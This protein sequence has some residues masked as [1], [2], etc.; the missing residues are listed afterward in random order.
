[1]DNQDALL[2]AVC[3]A[4]DLLSEST[5]P[6]EQNI[7]QVLRRLG[8]AAQAGRVSLFENHPASGGELVMSLRFE[9]TAPGVKPQID[10]LGSQ[11]V[12]YAAA[13]LIRWPDELSQGHPLSGV[14]RAFPEGE[15]DW[16]AA[17]GILSFA[18]VPVFARGAWWGWVGAADCA[19]ERIWTGAQIQALSAVART[20]G[21]ALSRE[22]LEKA[23][24]E[25]EAQ[26]LSIFEATRDGLVIHALDGR[27]VEVNPSFCRMHGLTRDEAIGQYPS[28]YVHP[29]SL[30]LFDLFVQSAVAGRPFQTQAWDVKKDG[31]EFPVEVRGSGFVYQGQPHLLGV[32]RDVS[33]RVQ[34]Y[35]LLERRVQE[36]TRELE[37]LLEVSQ[38]VTLTLKL[39]PLLA[40]LLVHLKAVVDYTAAAVFIV[41]GPDRLKLLNY[42]GPLPKQELATEWDLN[43][44]QHCRAVIDARTPVILPDVAAGGALEQAFRATAVAQLGHAPDHAGTWM[45]VPLIAREQVV[46]LLAL[47]HGQPDFY[48][49][50]QAHLALAFAYQAAGAM[51]N[52]RLYEAELER[53]AE[54]EQR[55]RVAEGLREILTLLN[56]NRPL[57]DVL[58]AIVD[59]A[60]RLLNPNA[61][62][63]FRVARDDKALTIHASH[64]LPVE[65]TARIKVPVGMGAVGRAVLERAPVAL[66]DLR[67]SFLLEDLGEPELS[68]LR[69]WLVERFGAL[70]AVPLLVRGETYGGIVLYYQQPREFHQDE[71]DLAVTLADQAA[72]AI[73]NARLFEQDRQLAVLQERQRLAR[74]L[75]DSVSQ[76]LY[77]IALGARTARTLLD[78]DA[79]RAAEPMDYVLSLAEAGLSEMRALIF[80]LRPESLAAEGLVT[81]LRKQADSARVRYGLRVKTAFCIEPDMPVPA[82]EALYRIAQEAI[83]N[84][85]KHAQATEVGLSLRQDDG[86]LELVVEDNGRGFDT[87]AAFPGHLGLHSMRERAAQVGGA[88]HIESAPGRGTRISVRI[89]L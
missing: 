50:P 72:L 59:Q 8:E 37:T 19:N 54:A 17:Q 6:W 15:R 26:G 39:R 10:T 57:A 62:A 86:Q 46:G 67:S 60:R 71:I 18:V 22:R 42:Y 88:F 75:H 2:D 36:R 24:R 80:E 56:S 45:G 66:G 9:W 64:G 28:L 31:T 16:L 78:R 41:T 29:N 76:A 81:A 13:G 14:A 58:D 63:I 74:E 84:T 87:G 3:F 52:A 55:R 33:E 79:P 65:Y 77:G 21:A 1:M 68:A 82:K 70:L 47:E 4:A 48:Q 69:G 30:P 43:R 89:P 23:L 73:E 83:H 7:H 11:N 40:T 38:N 27:L 53:R 49:E 25:A 12:P 51:E 5:E 32:V 20:F 35:S 34:A 61:V 44:A 85:G